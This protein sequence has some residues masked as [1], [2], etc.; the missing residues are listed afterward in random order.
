MA[1]IVGGFNDD[2]LEGTQ[3]NDTILMHWGY[4]IAQGGGGGDKFISGWTLRQ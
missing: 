4:D 2:I 1:K 3:N